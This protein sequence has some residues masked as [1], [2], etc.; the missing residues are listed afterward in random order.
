MGGSA[1]NVF[2]KIPPNQDSTR[3]KIFAVRPAKYELDR[4]NPAS[5]YLIDILERF[6]GGTISARSAK[7]IT[8]LIEVAI[9][10]S[11]GAKVE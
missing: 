7:G 4:W 10:G 6:L 11:A 8:R 2:K 9:I 1:E 5:N 3:A